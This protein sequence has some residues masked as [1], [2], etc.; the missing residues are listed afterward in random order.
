MRPLALWHI[1]P[2]NRNVPVMIERIFFFM[3]FHPETA[4]LK[5]KTEIYQGCKHKLF[6]FLAD[7]K[8][9]WSPRRTSWPNPF[10]FTL[11]LISLLSAPKPMFHN[12]SWLCVSNCWWVYDETNLYSYSKIQ[13]MRQLLYLLCHKDKS[14]CLIICI[15]E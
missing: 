12:Q 4:S 14:R 6:K 5:K 10:I 13:V 1:Q 11:I 8:V 15:F 2:N 7:C 3:R 9:T